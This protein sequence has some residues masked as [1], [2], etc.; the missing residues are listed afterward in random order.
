[1]V[2]LSAPNLNKFPS[3]KILN[4]ITNKISLFE[5]VLITANDELV[6]YFLNKK[7]NYIDINKYLNKIISLKQFSYYKTKSLEI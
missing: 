5:T 2:D 3:L 4:K 1:M 7:L 6:K